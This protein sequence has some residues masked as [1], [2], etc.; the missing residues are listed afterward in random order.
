MPR[1]SA[2]IKVIHASADYYEPLFRARYVRAMK[3]LQKK[4]SINALAMSMGNAKQAKDL[5]PQAD[6]VKALEPLQKV[7][8][9]AFMRGGKLGASHVSEL[10]KHG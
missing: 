9:D 7:I 5:I 4:T 8:R 6:I 3:A 10:L 2:E 1:Q